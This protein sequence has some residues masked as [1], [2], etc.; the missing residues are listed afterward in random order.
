MPHIVENLRGQEF[1]NA[2]VYK[3]LE[4]DFKI[5]IYER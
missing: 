3:E 5:T 2:K 1:Q 4:F